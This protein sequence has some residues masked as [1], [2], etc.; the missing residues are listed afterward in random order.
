M[1]DVVGPSAI[2][3]IKEDGNRLQSSGLTSWLS[4]LAETEMQADKHTEPEADT[5]TDRH[6]NTV[7]DMK[8]DRHTE[9]E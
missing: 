9:S 1:F 5:K 7:T 2:G 3:E 4:D 6:S 8:T